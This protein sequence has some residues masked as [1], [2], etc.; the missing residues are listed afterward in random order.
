MNIEDVDFGGVL[1]EY[2]DVLGYIHFA[3][4][5]RLAP[6]RGHID[7]APVFNALN[8]LE[9]DGWIGVEVLPQPTPEEAAR[10]SIEFIRKDVAARTSRKAD[11]R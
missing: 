7:F 5:N 2:R 9:Y 11:R 3:D 8:D 1:Q 10:Q 4:S 6:G